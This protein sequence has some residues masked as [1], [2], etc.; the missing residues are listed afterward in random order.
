MNQDENATEILSRL[1][2]GDGTAAQRLMPFVYDE[3]RALAQSYF[4]A[5]RDDHTLEPTALVHEVFLRIIDQTRVS[6]EGKAHFMATAATAMRRILTDHA[7]RHRALKRGRD[8]KRVT[9][10]DIVADDNASTLGG[11]TV[12]LVVLDDAL[13]RWRRWTNANTESSSF[14]SSAVSA[15][16]RWLISSDC[17]NRRLSVNGEWSKHG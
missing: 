14:D 12:D 5:E 10:S 7:R 1:A 9:L 8:H 11:R 4:Q 3:L 17:P 13:A 6:W 16:I 15:S 2:D